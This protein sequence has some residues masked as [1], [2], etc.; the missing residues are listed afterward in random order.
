MRRPGDF[1]SELSGG[2]WNLVEEKEKEESWL[3]VGKSWRPAASWLSRVHVDEQEREVAENRGA[4]RRLGT[5][6]SELRAQPRVSMGDTEERPQRRA[7]Q[8]SSQQAR[9]SSTLGVK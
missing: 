3:S 8:R 4:P 6:R 9:A 5:A 1:E 7:L 2:N